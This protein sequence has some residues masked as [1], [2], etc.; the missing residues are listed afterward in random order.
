MMF[1]RLLLLF[2][3]VPV[4]ELY[5]LIKAGQAIGTMN[6]VALVILTGIV[7]ASFAKSQG[8]QIISKIRTQLSQGQLPGR[9]LLQGAM[10]LAGG[11][12]LVTP[13]FITDLVGLSLLFPLT[14]KLY[15]DLTLDYFKKKFET[16][17]WK[18]SV[19]SNYRWPGDNEPGDSS[20]NNDEDDP[21]VYQADYEE[22]DKQ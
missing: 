2:T 4:V 8:A 9:D 18:Y 12:L 19:Y 22:I 15:T 17:Q 16:G 6:T 13:G 1:V 5:I 20:D 7:G 21:D 10:I 3:I 14:R 11:I